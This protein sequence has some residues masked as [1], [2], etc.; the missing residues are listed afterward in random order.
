MTKTINQLTKPELIDYIRELESR[1][2]LA[3]AQANYPENLGNRAITARLR[4]LEIQIVSAL[5]RYKA[6]TPTY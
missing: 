6:I 3:Y 2:S 4:A 5:N 1:I